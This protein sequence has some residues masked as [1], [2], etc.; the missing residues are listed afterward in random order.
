MNFQNSLEF[1]QQTDKADKLSAYRQRFL[2]PE[3]NGRDVVY[4][5]GNSLGLQPKTTQSYIQQELEDW[6]KFGVE[7]HFLAKHPWMPYHEFLTEKMAKVV[8]ALP[9]ETVMMN[10]LTVNIHLLMVSFY[11]PTKQLSLIHI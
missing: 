4:F 5:T 1:A 9:E 3:H 8:G 10:Q 7:G 6:A 11:R 2:V